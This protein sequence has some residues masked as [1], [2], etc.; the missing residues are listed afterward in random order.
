MQMKF[1]WFV[2]IFHWNFICI[3]YS[4]NL[5]RIMMLIKE[6]NVSQSFSYL[7]S[8]LVNVLK[9]FTVVNSKNTEKS[10]ASP[11]VLVSHGTAE[12]KIKI[13]SS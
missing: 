5:S 1:P 12:R 6:F 10:F 13:A 4:L 3:F 8:V 7:F 2:S 9:R 11:H